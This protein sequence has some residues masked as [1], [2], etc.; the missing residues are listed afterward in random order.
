MNNLVA[1]LNWLIQCAEHDDLKSIHIEVEYGN[2]TK[3]ITECQASD[4]L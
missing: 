3:E 4:T 1:T 2:G